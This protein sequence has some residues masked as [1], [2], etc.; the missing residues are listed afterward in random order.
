[1]SIC[2]KAQ[3][4]VEYIL[5]FA[6]VVSLIVVVL[7]KNGF[8]PKAVDNSLNSMVVGIE[9]MA[10][11]ADGRLKCGEQSCGVDICGRSCGECKGTNMF[12]SEEGQCICDEGWMACCEDEGCSCPT[13][14]HECDGDTCVKKLNIL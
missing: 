2:K 11:C 9:L 8:F 5:V 7:S 14:T 12:C 3:S 1:M 10:E 13:E 6:V 4:T